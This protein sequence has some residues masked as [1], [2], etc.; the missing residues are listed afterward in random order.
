M[1][2]QR[3]TSFYTSILSGIRID[4]VFKI[5]VRR[6]HLIEDALVAVSDHDLT[7][8]WQVFSM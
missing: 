4:P 1:Y 8:L 7:S 3:H 5:C 2:R 6:N